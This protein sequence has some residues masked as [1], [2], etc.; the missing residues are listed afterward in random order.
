MNKTIERFQQMIH[1]VFLKC[2]LQHSYRVT[3]LHSCIVTDLQSYRV[4]ES[5]P[6]RHALTFAQHEWYTIDPI[7]ATNPSDPVHAVDPTKRSTKLTAQLS[8]E[9]PGELERQLRGQ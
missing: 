1:H 4:T 9:L 5:C 8:T 2:L 7:E 3:E 6:D